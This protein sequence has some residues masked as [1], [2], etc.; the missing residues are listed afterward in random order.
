MADDGVNKNPEWVTSGNNIRGLIKE[1]N[2]LKD[3]DMEVKISTDGGETFKC[4]SI[5]IKAGE[6]NSTFCALLNCE[7]DT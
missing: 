3:Q 7:E 1:L 4:I 5:I 6:D 2:T